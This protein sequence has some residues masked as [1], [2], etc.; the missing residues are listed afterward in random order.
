MIIP[1]HYHVI[2]RQ[3]CQKLTEFANKQSQSRFPQYQCTFQIWWNS[4]ETYSRYWPPSK[5]QM[6]CWQITLS[7]MNEI[8]PLPIQKQISTIPMHIK[9]FG[10]NPLIFTYCPDNE[11]TD[12]LW[13]DNSVKKLMKFAHQQSQTRSLQYQCTHQDRWKSIDIY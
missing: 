7:K 12:I 10:E 8:C 4:I 6:Y 2:G 5:I 1:H 13:A 11:K 9:K 3:L